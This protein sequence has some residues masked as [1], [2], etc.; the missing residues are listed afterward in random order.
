MEQIR[1]AA[2]V[3][4]GSLYHLFPDKLTLAAHLFSAGMQECQT[5]LL[6]TLAALRICSIEVDV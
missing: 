3:S 5:G 2:G 1:K 6:E 4:N